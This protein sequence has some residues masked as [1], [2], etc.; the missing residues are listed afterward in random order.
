MASASTRSSASSVSCSGAIPSLRRA[1]SST[2]PLR[3]ACASWRR[4]IPYSHATAGPLSGRWRCAPASAAANVSAVRSA[5]SSASRV[6]RAKYASSAS[7]V[8]A[9]EDREGLGLGARGG[10]QIVVGAF[11]HQLHL[12]SRA[13]VV[14]EASR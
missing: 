8:A 1:R 4:A 14:T 3:A 9:V 2:A 5:A 11:V 12:V 7:H 6:R 10:E 13:G